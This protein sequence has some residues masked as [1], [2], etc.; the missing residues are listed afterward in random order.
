MLIVSTCN[1][2]QNSQ[3]LTGY[4][5]QLL[6]TAEQDRGVTQRGDVIQQ[7]GG[8][9]QRGGVGEQVGGAT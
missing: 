6:S 4:E 5:P 2:T 8:A 1:R 7:V 9:T 3:Q